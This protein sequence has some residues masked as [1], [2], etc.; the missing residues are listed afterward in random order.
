MLRFVFWVLLIPL[1]WLGIGLWFVLN[2]TILFLV[3]VEPGLEM[4]LRISL[5]VVAV[6][7]VAAVAAAVAAGFYALS[8]SA[9]VRYLSKGPPA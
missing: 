1:S 5:K 3:T 8:A 9:Q 2:L 7:A 6:A 4:L